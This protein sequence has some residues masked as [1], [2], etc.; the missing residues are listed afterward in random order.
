MLYPSIRQLM[1]NIGSRYLLVNVTSVRAREIA[2]FADRNNIPLV[3]KPV[4]MAINEIAEGKL[5]GRVKQDIQL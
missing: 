4:K 3:E 5:V 1:N 2:D